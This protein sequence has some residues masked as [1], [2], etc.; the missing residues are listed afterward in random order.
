MRIVSLN[1]SNTEIVAALGLGDQLVGC[2]DD[3]DWPVD[4]VE[5]QPRVGRDLN[6]DVA[7]VAALKPDL[8]L[9]SLTVPG[10][11]QV[12]EQVR[13]AGLPLYAPETIT[14]ADVHQDIREIASRAGVPDRAEP[15]VADLQLATTSPSREPSRRPRILVQ[16]WPKPVIAPG[17]LSWVNEMIRAAGGINPLGD[18][19]VKSE[20]MSDVQVAACQPDAIVLAWCGVPA[21]KVRID[22]VTENPQFATCPAVQN[23]RVVRI[24]EAFLG[25]PGPR[26]IDGMR[27]LRSVVV[28]TATA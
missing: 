7:A 19:D 5:N 28:S 4:I 13:A 23:N 12:V 22:V 25:R 17:K 16:W 1:C 26:L 24:P 18:R 10:H 20:P 9:G 21:A 3:S 15:L 6:I 14:L 8:V 27:E 11:E 2:D